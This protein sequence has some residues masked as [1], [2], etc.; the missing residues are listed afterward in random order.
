MARDAQKRAYSREVDKIR[1]RTKRAIERLQKQEA[2]SNNYLVKRQ[3]RQQI[4][5]LQADLSNLSA[6]GRQRT[7]TDKAKKALESLSSDSRRVASSKQLSRKKIDFQAEVAKAS[8]GGISVLGSK[9]REKVQIFYRVTQSI[10]NRPD[11]PLRDRNKA[12]MQALGVDSL[13]AAWA[14]IMNRPDVR[15]ALRSM[16]TSGKPVADTDSEGAAYAEAE[17]TQYEIDTPTVVMLL[18]MVEG[19]KAYG[20]PQ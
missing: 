20:A 3:A 2:E 7:Y 4:E 16:D 19:T 14:K 6:R 12:I 8:R 9:P 1:K 10:W 5:A 15:R 13:E 11:V 18:Q 17:R